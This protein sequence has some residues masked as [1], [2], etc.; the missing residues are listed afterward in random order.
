VPYI[1]QAARARLNSNIKG[2][3]TPGEL[4]YVITIAILRAFKAHPKYETIHQLKQDFV[5]EARHNEFLKKLVSF[6]AADFT[7]ADVMTAAA[8]AFDEFYRRVA[9]K[10]EDSKIASQGDVAEYA[11]I[12]GLFSAQIA[13]EEKALD[14]E[15][16]K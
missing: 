13:E 9:S 12:S 5:V 14:E 16:A 2:I 10:Y 7:T 3:T 6:L 4:N 8:L 1:D 15:I 11:E